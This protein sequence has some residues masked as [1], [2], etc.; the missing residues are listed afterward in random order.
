MQTTFCAPV[1]VGLAH[2]GR[3]TCNIF[4]KLHTAERGCVH[5]GHAAGLWS[6]IANCCSPVVTAPS[7]LYCSAVL[8]PSLIVRHMLASAFLLPD[9]QACVT[10]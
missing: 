4:S 5:E 10:P 2:D 8:D 3:A 6:T 1:I 7:L 9:S